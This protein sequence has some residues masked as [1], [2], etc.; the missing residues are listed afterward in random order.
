V[1]LN[2]D[3]LS[4]AGLPAAGEPVCLSFDPTQA[5]QVFPK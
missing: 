1:R 4:R 5:L 2:F 3:F